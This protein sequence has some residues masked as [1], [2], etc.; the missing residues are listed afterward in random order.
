MD[1]V[2]KSS[3]RPSSVDKDRTDTTASMAP[4]HQLN[5]CWKTVKQKI[6]Y[7]CILEGQSTYS[8]LHPVHRSSCIMQGA[9]RAARERARC[10]IRVRAIWI[11]FRTSAQLCKFNLFYC[12]RNARER[13]LVYTRESSISAVDG[14]ADG[15]PRR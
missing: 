5:K 7:L 8:R 9:E 14:Y 12:N 3:N 13:G 1:T 6:H 11:V 15:A 2:D 4:T 10:T